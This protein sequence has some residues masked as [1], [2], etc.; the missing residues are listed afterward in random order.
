MEAEDVDA[1]LGRA[2]DEALCE[3][4]VYRPGAD[5]EASTQRHRQRRLRARADCADPLPWALHAAAHG[6]LEAA[7]AGDLEVRE[8][9]GVEDLGEPQLLGRRQPPGEGLLPEQAKRRVG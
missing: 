9:G 1:A 5:E 2:G 7:A 8:A 4:D 3:I 6:G